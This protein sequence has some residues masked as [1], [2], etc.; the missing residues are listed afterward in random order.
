[1]T[2]VMQYQMVP[3]YF[4]GCMPFDEAGGKVWAG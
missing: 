1:M 2:Q 4:N 3:G